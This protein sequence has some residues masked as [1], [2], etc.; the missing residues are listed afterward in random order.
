ML[1][2]SNLSII[3]SGPTSIYL[4]NHILNQINRFK[5]EINTLTIFEKD[6]QIGMGMPYNPKVTD[7]YNL[8]NISSEEIPQLPETFSNWLRKQS[9]DLLASLHINS[10]AIQDDEV[11]S[12]VALGHYFQ[13]QFKILIQSLKKEG[14]KIIE[15]SETEVIDI[16]KIS[17]EEY[18]VFYNF[19]YS[20]IF[21]AVVIANGHYWIEKDKPTIGYYASPWPIHKLFPQKNSYYNF[22]IGTLGASLSAF[23]V[24]SSL[25]HRHGKFFQSHDGLRFEKHENA[26]KF[27]IVL[28]TAEGWL[29]HLQYEQEEPIREIYR[30]FERNDI[31]NLISTTGFLRIEEYFD[32]LCRPA[33]IRAFKKDKDLTMV[34]QL[35]SENCSFEKFIAI[36]SDRH[37]YVNSF[38][39]MRRE[40]IEAKDSIENNKPIHWMETL[41][42]LMYSLNYHAELLPAEDHQF[43]KKKVKTFL[44]NV[45]AALPLQSAEILLAL[46][47]AG[48]INIK[49]GKVKIHEK[50]S[51]QGNTKVTIETNNGEL[52]EIEYELFIN[53]GGQKNL[54]IHD[55]PFASLVKEGNLREATSKF[56]NPINA[57]QLKNQNLLTLKQDTYHMKLG[58]IQIDAAYR[59]IDTNECV[60]ENLFD[61]NFTHTSGLRP[62]AY[63]LQACNANSLILVDSWIINI[64]EGKNTSATSMNIT[65]LYEDEDG[66]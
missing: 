52:E 39:G 34:E 66:L 2:L 60:N 51:K 35:K 56:H 43:F 29:P 57:K 23:D 17:E 6:I 10:Y 27:K 25:S 18:E 13:D 11:Y 44:N 12:R 24:V 63:G 20:T 36:M 64:K 55:F 47:D 31:T 42:D 22:T 59:T 32:Q 40:M 48:C 28:H 7:I 14:I 16:L 61:I 3:G 37:D 46:Y 65:E 41:D 19:E 54:E 30:H 53:C 33:L 1:N 50:N 38:E 8:A 5:G 58:G 15:R 26:E 4:L 9:D 49:T 62:Y 21:S 45:I